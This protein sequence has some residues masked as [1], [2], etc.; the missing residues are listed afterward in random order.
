MAATATVA[1][2]TPS[3]MMSDAD[4]TVWVAEEA[5]RIGWMNAAGLDGSP[6]SLRAA[7]PEGQVTLWHAAGQEGRTDVCE[8]LKSKGLLDLIERRQGHGFTALHYTLCFQ[9]EEAARWMDQMKNGSSTRWRK[10]LS[11]KR[12]IAAS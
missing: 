12:M 7:C 9:N 2:A 11:Q 8:Y 3:P 4:M 6:G 10:T 1:D 5:E